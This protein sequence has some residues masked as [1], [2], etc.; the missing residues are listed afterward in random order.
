MFSFTIAINTVTKNHFQHLLIVVTFKCTFVACQRS[1]SYQQTHR[2]WSISFFRIKSISFSFTLTFVRDCTQ[3]STWVLDLRV[4]NTWVTQIR[5]GA[6]AT[7]HVIYGT[8]SLWRLRWLFI[9]CTSLGG[10]FCR[11][12]NARDSYYCNPSMNGFR[13]ILTVPVVYLMKLFILH[14]Y[15]SMGSV[16]EDQRN[17]GWTVWR[18]NRLE[19]GWLLKL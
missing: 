5:R 1:E 4:F 9:E 12:L 7:T 19:R 18:I 17:N 14:H 2:L 16:E 15:K 11:R 8:V 13:S 10:R 3:E 6:G